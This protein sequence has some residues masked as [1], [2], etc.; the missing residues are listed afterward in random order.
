MKPIFCSSCLAMS[1]RPRIIFD[2]LGICNACNWAKKKETEINWK[3]REL[4]LKNL[5]KLENNN[6]FSCLVPV[7]GGKDGSYVAYNLKHKYKANPLCVT[8]RPALPTP[9]GY[10]FFCKIRLSNDHSRCRL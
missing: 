3:K 2:R 4:E 7:S 10:L 5:L 9:L 8:I 6:S 1:T